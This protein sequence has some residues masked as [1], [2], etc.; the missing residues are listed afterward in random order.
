M[1]FPCA[2]TLQQS[3]KNCSSIKAGHYIVYVYAARLLQEEKSLRL[4]VGIASFS[5]EQLLP[6][7]D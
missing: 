4:L 1:P 2:K 5:S 7:Y 3:E 6:A